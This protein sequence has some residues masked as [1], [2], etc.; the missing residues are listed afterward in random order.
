[1]ISISYFFWSAHPDR[2]RYSQE[3]SDDLMSC[4]SD[5]ISCPRPPPL[6]EA[7]NL[8]YIKYTPP[9]LLQRQENQGI[10]TSENRGLI[11]SSGTTGF[12]TWEA[13]LHLGT[14]LSTPEGKALVHDKNVVELGAGTGFVSMYCAKHLG[15]NSVAATDREPALIANIQDCVARNDLQSSRIEAL[16]WEWGNPLTSGVG[17]TSGPTDP[18]RYEIAL[19]A[20]LV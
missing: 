3:I 17:A 18:Q 7:Q 14:Y 1:M 16:I 19:G 8:S 6:E 5:L 13:A 20:D 9:G 2:G 12:R 10:I 15:A 11:L 4:Y